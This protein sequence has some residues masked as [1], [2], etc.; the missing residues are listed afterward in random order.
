MRSMFRRDAI[1]HI[2]AWVE[3]R[4]ATNNR[5]LWDYINRKVGLSDVGIT[6]T[7]F[8]LELAPKIPETRKE[9]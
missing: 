5:S 2:Q 3:F 1:P 6:R 7:N 9:G 4:F 8:L